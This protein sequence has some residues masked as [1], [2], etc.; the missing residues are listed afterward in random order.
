M[1]QIILIP[2]SARWT[3]ELTKSLFF[4]VFC[5]FGSIGFTALIVPFG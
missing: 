3:L 4:Y 1:L 5:N 2:N